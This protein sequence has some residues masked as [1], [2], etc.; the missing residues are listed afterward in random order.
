MVSGPEHYELAEEL[1]GDVKLRGG[2]Y[3]EE[4]R[5]D[6]IA[7]AQ[8]HATLA[9]AAATALAAA[10]RM[11]I[12]EYQAWADVCGEPA[13]DAATAAAGHNRSTDGGN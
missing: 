7:L 11:P 10:G 12:Y 5:A 1:I 4:G 3:T 13:E 8:V 2:E 6:A 9:H